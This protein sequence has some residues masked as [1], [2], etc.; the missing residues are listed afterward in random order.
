MRIES[1]DLLFLR[2]TSIWSRAIRLRS[3][4]PFS[5]VGLAIRMQPP[6]DGLCVIESLEPYG[7][8]LVPFSVWESWQAPIDVYAPVEVNR[9]HVLDEAA[10]HLG[11]R[12]ASPLQFLRSWGLLTRRLAR[13]FG[14]SAD[15]D[16]RRFFCSE[17]VATALRAG[18][19]RL[20]A[21]PAAMT[22][23]D[24]A[25]LSCVRHKGRLFP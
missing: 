15:T 2:G 14:W 24:V 18:G 16:S 8:R 11:C 10:S 13:R 23:G 6:F 20:H 19:A 3:E 21:A 7:V 25:L 22:P 12:Y 1:G 9:E 5:H 4:S 17:L